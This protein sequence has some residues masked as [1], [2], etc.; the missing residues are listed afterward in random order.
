[1]RNF[2]NLLLASAVC[3]AAFAFAGCSDDDEDDNTISQTIEMD[4]VKY[5]NVFALY[6]EEKGSDEINIDIDTDR[7]GDNNV[8]GYGY[9]DASLIGKTV[10]LTADFDQ[11]NIGFNFMTGGFFAPE[12]KSGTLTISKVAKG[13]H[14]LLKS[15]NVDDKAF[16]MDILLI[17]E[18]EYF[19]NLK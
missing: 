7:D 3:I 15:T 19:K 4:G 6:H 18:E 17:D 12:Y 8:H 2:K 10:N 14:I 1:M 13:Y 9:F 11:L 16:N 5:S